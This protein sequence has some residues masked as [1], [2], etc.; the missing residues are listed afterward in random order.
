MTWL[1]ITAWRGIAPPAAGD[2]TDPT[3]TQRAHAE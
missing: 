2:P 3:F 1:P